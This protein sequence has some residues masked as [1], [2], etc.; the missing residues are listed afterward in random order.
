M[1]GLF[2]VYA[3]SKTA[4]SCGGYHAGLGGYVEY[5]HLCRGNLS[6]VHDRSRRQGWAPSGTEMGSSTWAIQSCR[7][8]Y[9]ATTVVIRNEV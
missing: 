2:P 3:Y 9:F 6:T 1:G 4:S 5:A 7:G 8:R